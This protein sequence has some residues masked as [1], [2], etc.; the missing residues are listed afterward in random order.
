MKNCPYCGNTLSD[1]TVVCQNCGIG[2]TSGP[3]V[4]FAEDINCPFCTRRHV[5]QHMS[6]EKSPRNAAFTGLG[7]AAF[8][9][10]TPLILFLITPLGRDEVCKAWYCNVTIPQLLLIGLVAGII[11]A[12]IAY[13]KS[14]E[15]HIRYECIDCHKTW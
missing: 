11:A 8:I 3:S 13:F 2:L 1:N 7:F 15:N 12:V 14:N 10:F 6:I 4:L 9:I 5:I